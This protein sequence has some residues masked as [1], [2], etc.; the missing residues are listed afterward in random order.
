MFLKKFIE[1]MGPKRLVDPVF[2][3]LLFMKMRETTKSYW[4]GSGVLPAAGN[5]W[6]IEYFIDADEPGPSQAQRDFYVSLPALYTVLVA[7][8]RPRL[9][10]SFA[11][12]TGRQIPA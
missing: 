6:E 7:A 10:Q 4:E 1:R 12:C 2:G 11:D 3:R 5:L 8:V 9:E